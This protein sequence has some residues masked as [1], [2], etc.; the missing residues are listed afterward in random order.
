MRSEPKVRARERL[1]LHTRD[2]FWVCVGTRHVYPCSVISVSNAFCRKETKYSPGE[3]IRYILAPQDI[4]CGLTAHL[5]EQ[6]GRMF[7]VQTGQSTQIA[8][9]D[10]AIKCVKWI[11]AQGGILV[12]GSWDKTLK[13]GLVLADSFL[14]HRNHIFSSIGIH[15]N[16]HPLLKSI[17]QTGVIRWTWLILFWLLGLQ[18]GIYKCSTSTI[19]RLH[20]G[21]V[22]FPFESLY[23]RE[24]LMTWI[25]ANSDYGFASEV[26]D[27]RDIMFHYRERICSRQY[28]RKSCHSVSTHMFDRPR[29][30]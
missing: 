16:Q 18:K 19:P 12:T 4:L 23:E 1:C 28:W 29:S 26:A 14:I 17:S 10:A 7:D 22:N 25:M 9:H 8:V 27:A 5:I 6:A 2:R 21:S 3:R 15:V 24:L 11:D 13:V 20:T 30:G